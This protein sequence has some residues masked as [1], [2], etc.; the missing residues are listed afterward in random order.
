MTQANPL[1]GGGRVLQNLRVYQVVENNDIR[2][3]QA[4]DAPQGNQSRVAGTG[5]HEQDFAKAD[6]SCHSQTVN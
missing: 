4:L 6:I 3:P 2:L 1:G 5:P